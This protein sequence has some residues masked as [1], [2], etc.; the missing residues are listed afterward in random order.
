MEDLIV[1]FEAEARAAD[2]A[3]AFYAGHGVQVGGRN[4]LLPVDARLEQ[5]VDLRRLVPADWLVEDA[6]LASRLALVILDA[7]RDNPLV[8]TLQ[9]KERSLGVGLGLALV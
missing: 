5:R 7:C 6:G 4:F 8:R 9:A 3:L 1:R 2:V